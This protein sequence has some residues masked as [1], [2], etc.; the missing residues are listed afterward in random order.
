MMKLCTNH[1]ESNERRDFHK[2]I[3]NVKSVNSV[4][5]L[6]FLFFCKM[7]VL[8]FVSVWAVRSQRRKKNKLIDSKE[9]YAKKEEF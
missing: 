5:L 2:L 6:V 7:Y 4:I 9:I 3:T 1:V 8:M